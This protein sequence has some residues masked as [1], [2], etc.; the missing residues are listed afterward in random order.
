MTNQEI[1][2]EF[3]GT[4]AKYSILASQSLFNNYEKLVKVE[5]EKLT[6]A[7]KG[8]EIRGASAVAFAVKGEKIEHDCKCQESQNMLDAAIKVL[9]DYK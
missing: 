5:I 8:A 1:A 6:L 7:L 3:V 2:A 4:F 9:E